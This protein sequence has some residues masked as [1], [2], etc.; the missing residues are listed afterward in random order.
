MKFALTSIIMITLGA[1]RA[2]ASCTFVE[3]ATD[4]QVATQVIGAGV[5]TTV[6]D[7]PCQATVTCPA[8]GT[9]GTVLGQNSGCRA[10]NAM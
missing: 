4:G 2:S 10:A 1:Y 9:G 6:T 7:G 3:T 5:R 8:S